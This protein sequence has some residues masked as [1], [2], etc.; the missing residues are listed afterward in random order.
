VLQAAF[1]SQGAAA[2]DSIGPAPEG[3]HGQHLPAKP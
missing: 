1:S 3:L 2:L